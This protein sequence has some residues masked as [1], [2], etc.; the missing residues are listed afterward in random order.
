LIVLDANATVFAVLTSM[1]LPGV[2]LVLSDWRC[3]SWS[4]RERSSPD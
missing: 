3:A 4:S 2:R 1:Y